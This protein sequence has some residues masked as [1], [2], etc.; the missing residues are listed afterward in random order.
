MPE[1]RGVDAAA[2]D[3]Q[4]V[5]H[6]GLAVGGEPPQVGAADHHRAGAERHRLDDV[7]SRGGCRRP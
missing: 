2:Q 6:A 3:V 4:D 5:L 1:Q 7:A